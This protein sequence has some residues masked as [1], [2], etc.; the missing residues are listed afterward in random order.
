VGIVGLGPMSN[1]DLSNW[2]VDIASGTFI[3]LVLLLVWNVSIANVNSMHSLL[4]M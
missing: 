4:I 3:F 2:H 1:V